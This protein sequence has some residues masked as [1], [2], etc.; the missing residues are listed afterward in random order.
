[1]DWLEEAGQTTS[2]KFWNLTADGRQFIERAA[3]QYPNRAELEEY[4]TLYWHKMDNW[5][6]EEEEVF[7][8]ARD[9]Y[10]RVDAMPSSRHVRVV[11]DGEMEVS[12]EVEAAWLHHRFTQ[13]HPFQDGNGRIARLLASLV[14]IKA[15]WFPLVVTR[16][17]RANSF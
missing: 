11:L 8:H 1:M 2:R 6:E 9:P 14:F 17:D 15:G 13:I 10:K 4:I 16:D 5:F 3:Y 12:P 7:V